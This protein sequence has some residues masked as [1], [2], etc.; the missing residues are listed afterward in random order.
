MQTR[1]SSEFADTA[2]GERAAEI[3]QRCVHCGFCN[4]TCPTYQ[5]EGNE[6]DGPRGRIYLIKNLLEGAED[7]TRAATHLDRCLTCRACE[8]TCPSG[9][10]YGELLEIGRAQVSP[11]HTLKQKLQRRA[12]LSFV[13]HPR[14]LRRWARLG[15]AF[16]WLLPESLRELLPSR[17][18]PLAIPA[19]TERARKVVVLQ[20]CAQSVA[21]PNVV[22]TLVHLLERMEVEAVIVPEESCC[23]GLALHLGE[24]DQAQ[25]AMRAQLDALRP[26]LDAEAVISSASGCGVTLKEYGRLLND[27]PAYRL[28]ARSFAEKVMDVSEYMQLNATRP[29]RKG[30]DFKRVAWHAPCTLQHGQQAGD[31]VAELLTQAGYELVPVADAHLC[32]GSAGTYSVLQPEL[33]GRLRERKLDAL[34]QAQPDVI[35]TGNVGCQSHLGAACRGAGTAL[36]RAAVVV[37]SSERGLPP[38]IETPRLRLRV[39]RP[40]DALTVNRAVRE[41]YLELTP[42]MEW[43]KELPT[44]SESES[45]AA[46]A[47]EKWRAGEEWPLLMWSKSSGELLGSTG[48]PNISWSVPKFEIGYWCHSQHTGNGYVTEAARAIARFV[49]ERFNARR[50]EIRA[51]DRNE[52]SWLVAERIGF[53]LEA[54]LHNDLKANDDSLRDT[55]VYAMFSAM[56]LR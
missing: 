12:L 39:P 16:R 10:E 17:Q 46:L 28:V 41:S 19:V 49:F 27:D 53:K 5:L 4:A 23:G 1:L 25:R 44:L 36:A 18:K 37:S 26:H 38:E 42:W 7:A 6:L 40:Q 51:D 15:Q 11:P 48:C 2:A 13:P 47:Q 3:L 30:Q 21:T 14:S 55:R 29:F 31:G 50:L 8:T 34:T 52:R 9:V 20:G 33:A 45:F 56:E 43:A 35:A 54:L 24:E 22:P 32:C